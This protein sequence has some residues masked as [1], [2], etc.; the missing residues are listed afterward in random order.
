MGKWTSLA[1]IT[2]EKSRYEITRCD[3]FPPVVISHQTKIDQDKVVDSN[4]EPKEVIERKKDN[5]NLFLEAIYESHP[6]IIVFYSYKAP[7]FDEDL[8]LFKAMFLPEHG[9][10]YVIGRFNQCGGE[11]AN[12]TVYA[13]PNKCFCVALFNKTK[14][15]AI[16]FATSFVN[17]TI[18]IG[19][20]L[21]GKPL[22]CAEI[23]IL[24]GEKHARSNYW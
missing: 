7:S 15:E 23:T 14:E 11:F 21:V 18:R 1:D 4:I 6:I 22:G 2:I 10:H 24:K 12:G 16:S 3:G 8:H 20:Y 5:G 17:K 19:A 9:C 13:I